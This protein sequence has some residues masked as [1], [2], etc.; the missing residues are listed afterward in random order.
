MIDG[1]AGGLRMISR[2]LLTCIGSCLLFTWL[3]IGPP[4]LK[5]G[6]AQ[7]VAY[8]LDRAGNGN[9]T[10]DRYFFE[11]KAKAAQKQ[12]TE[13]LVLLEKAWELKPSH[14]IAGNLGQVAL[15]L[16]RYKKACVFLDRCLRLFPPTGNAEQRVQIQTLFESARA[17]VAEVKIL[18]EPQPGELVIDRATVVGPAATPSEPVFVDPGTHVLQIRRDG[19]VVAETSF[20]AVANA[21]HDIMVSMGK[22][23]P[24]GP[25]ASANASGAVNVPATSTEDTGSSDGFLHGR[26]G[27]PVVVG[28]TVFVA[29]F[30]SAGLLLHAAS[31]E[32]DSAN[33]LKGEI[34]STNSGNTDGRC[35]Q[36]APAACAELVAANQR[37][38][39]RYNWGYAMLGL[40]G[41]SLVATATYIFWP[42]SH[43]NGR[44][45]SN[46]SRVPS[47]GFDV[48]Q[49][50][51]R[52]SLSVQ[53]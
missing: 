36:V 28:T 25:A 18:V 41:A 49:Q 16:G 53:F 9:T 23:S 31:D 6:Q 5:V 10:A 13:A 48:Q 47:V 39:T 51:G 32:V 1:R 30:V 19:H 4:W 20:L 26:S 29:G 52:V 22:S 44:R 46:N 34:R 24:Q 14:D 7:T 11:A 37:A 40:G 21:S 35:P 27:W 3:Q 33:Q 43:S 42:S 2:R 45:G 15:K 17:H 8:P 50:S 12:W 38:D